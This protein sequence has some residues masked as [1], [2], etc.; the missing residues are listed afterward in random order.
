MMQ[1][2]AGFKI[3]LLSNV[4]SMLK[5]VLSNKYIPKTCFR[6]ALKNVKCGTF[7]ALVKQLNAI[8]NKITSA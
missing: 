2:V 8:Q 7:E 3:A 4:K 1:M 6:N 5:N